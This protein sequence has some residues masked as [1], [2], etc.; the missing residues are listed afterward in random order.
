MIDASSSIEACA[1]HYGDQA[2]AMRTYLISGQERALA[3]PNRGPLH[4]D[5]DGSL[6]DRI[7]NAYSE[8]GF[9]IFENVLS[10]AELDDIKADLDVMRAEFPTGPESKVNANGEPALGAD[11]K[12]LTL[13]LSLIHI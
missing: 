7:R 2:D 11:A 3:L 10:E 9:Y 8:Y 5:S 6:A 12:A 4:F 13:V 1:N